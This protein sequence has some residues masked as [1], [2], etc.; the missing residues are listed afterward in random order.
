MK[1]PNDRSTLDALAKPRRGR[2]PKPGGPVSSADR[3]RAQRRRDS[4]RTIGRDAE[5]IAE[6][7]HSGLMEAI[8]RASTEDDIVTLRL[9]IRELARRHDL[10]LSWR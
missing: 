3:K 2:P 8:Q 9:L 4:L 7:T 10:R 6:L 1:D 5:R